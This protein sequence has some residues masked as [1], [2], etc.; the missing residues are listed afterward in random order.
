MTERTAAQVRAYLEGVRLRV[1]DCRERFTK[2][3]K[4]EDFAEV[5][6]ATRQLRREMVRLLG[7]ECPA[8]AGGGEV[9][10]GLLPGDLFSPPERTWGECPECHGHGKI[11]ADELERWKLRHPEAWEDYQDARASREATL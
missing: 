1:T 7:V 6:K 5:R 9:P 3:G 2:S 11:L 10:D 4:P 8:C